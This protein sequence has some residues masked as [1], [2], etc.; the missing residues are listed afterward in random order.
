[1]QHE[2]AH[3]DEVWVTQVVDEAADVAV[4]PGVN[5]VHLPILHRKHTKDH[6]NKQL[7]QVNTRQFRTAAEGPSFTFRSFFFSLIPY[8][9]IMRFI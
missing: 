9:E 8:L 6:L 7:L 2:H 4:V 3:R 1:M 5:A